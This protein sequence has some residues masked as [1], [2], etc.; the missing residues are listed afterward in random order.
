MPYLTVHDTRLYYEDAGTGKP[1]LFLHGWGTSGRVWGAQ[2]P[3]FAAEHRVVVPDWRGCGRSDHPATSND[4][5]GVVT[6]LIALIGALDLDRPVVVGSSVG[7]VF[8][9]ELALRRPDLVGGVVAVD[10]PGY[11][12]AQGMDLPA[13]MSA[14][15]GDR[16]GFAT[17]WVANWY[18][19]GTSPA[20][21][22]WTV[23]QI[24]DSST[25]ADDQF[26][27]FRTYDPR[28]SLPGLRVPIHYLHGELDAEIPV[29]V[30]EDCAART[31]G[32]TVTVIPGSGHLPH[33]ERP[34]EFN[35]ALRAVLG[36][37][38]TT[39]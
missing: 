30:A 27:Q 4:V 23:R 6:D 38:R 20:L 36:R 13:I 8:G 22:D 29:A 2:L 35:A 7:G 1:V 37:L 5:D 17:A 31:P 26:A 32:A 28:P 39:V 21:V 18:A 34:A 11:W 15:R 3:E 9:T 12:P 19:P 33:Q 24:L 10:S 25:F 16:A 14:I